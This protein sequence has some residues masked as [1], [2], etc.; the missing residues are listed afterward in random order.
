MFTCRRPPFVFCHSLRHSTLAF[1]VA[2]YWLLA[3]CPLQAANPAVPFV[4]I[5]SPVSITPGSTGVIVT[6]R[7]AGFVASSVVHW[8]GVALLT[9][10][11]SPRELTATVPDA[12]VAAVGLGTV[13]IIS[14]APGGRVVCQSGS[15]NTGGQF[16]LHH[17]SGHHRHDRRPEKQ[18]RH[19]YFD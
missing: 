1:L 14:P 17:F 10:F 5:V 3:S 2:A 6:I 12:L 15:S 13:T 9:T 7:G 4:D 8:N 16:F 11:V 19:H 18:H